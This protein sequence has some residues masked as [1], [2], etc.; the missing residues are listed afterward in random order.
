MTPSP[1]SIS[2]PTLTTDAI[3]AAD[4]GLEAELDEEEIEEIF[5]DGAA[6]PF[7]QPSGDAQERVREQVLDEAEG[8]EDG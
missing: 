4:G 3:L 8:V 5:G 7:L 1:T 2:P 6:A